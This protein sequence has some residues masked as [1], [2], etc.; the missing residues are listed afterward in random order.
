MGFTS[1]SGGQALCAPL[2]SS[3]IL[4]MPRVELPDQE[5]E[6]RRNREVAIAKI[7]GRH[8]ADCWNSHFDSC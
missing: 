5:S 3:P 7:L 6:A 2:G 1:G 8:Q 4:P